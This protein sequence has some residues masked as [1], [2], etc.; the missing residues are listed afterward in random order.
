[1]P[2]LSAEGISLQYRGRRLFDGASFA[3]ER[4][5]RVG[6]VGPNGAGKSTL[7]RILAGDLTPDGGRVSRARGLRV[8]YLP[9]EIAAAPS[10]TLIDSV[11]AAAPGRLEI[12]GRIE[13]V[14]AELEASADHDAQLALAEA[15]AEL[16]HERADLER[17][18]AKHRAQRI[19][20][21][22]GF[23]N[24]QHARSVAELSGG[25]RMRAAL[26][27]LLFQNPDVL[28]LDEPTNHLDLPTVAWLN[29]FL[30][31]FH[32]ALVLICHDREFLNRHARR[33]ASLELEG[34]RTYRGNY[35]DYLVQREL[36]IELLEARAKKEEQRKKEL[37]GFVE[38]FRAK[39]SKARQAQSKAKQIEKLEAQL[40]EV[41]RAR[42]SV[43]LRFAPVSR[44]SETVMGLRGLGHAYGSQ[45]VFGGLDLSVRRGDRIVLVGLNG[46]GKTTLLRIMAG[47]LEP[48]DGEVE[49]G[50]HVE[51]RY[52][53]QHHAEDLDRNRTVL[54]EVWR[55]KPEASE[56][57]VRTLCG[58]F[59]FSGD[60]VDKK[61]A[62]LSG[63]EK[64]RV[65]LARLLIRPGNVLL[66]DEPTNHLDT[67]SAEKLTASLE[68]YDGTLIFVSHDVDFARRLSNKVWDVH[69]GVVETYPGSLSDYLTRLGEARADDEPEVRLSTLNGPSATPRDDDPRESKKEARIR[70]REAEAERRK[71]KSALEK[72]VSQAEADVARLEAEHTALEAELA[73]PATHVDHARARSRAQAYESVKRS[74]EA[75][76]TRWSSLGEELQR[77]DEESA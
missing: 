50:L 41:P 67:E 57:E 54:E 29:G 21:G 33:I 32:H 23:P 48:H 10:G 47:E 7:M 2:L 59:L 27:G 55:A 5:D 56:T 22:L 75:A 64:A 3:V 65:A 6:I 20:A 46:A 17:T 77:F 12:D 37:E 53:A 42:R 25:W 73:D 68:S 45:R 51:R 66:L 35:D 43:S 8:G 38:R 16:T 39:A 11:L 24:D 14:Q 28:L 19:L 36:E 18:Y 58:A 26:A 69:D 74:L 4:G 15:L 34:L 62:V 13:A 71:K 30:R 40:V 61:I 72:R 76:I 31:S 60:D 52:F 63:G 1:M 49:V 44:T 70:A 9:Q